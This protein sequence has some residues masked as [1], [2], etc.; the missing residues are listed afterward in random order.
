MAGY[1]YGPSENE[2]VLNVTAQLLREMAGRYPV[3]ELLDRNV[4]L[5]LQEPVREV[6]QF[7]VETVLT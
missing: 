3:E 1:D 7:V 5:E 4:V 6:Q 2:L